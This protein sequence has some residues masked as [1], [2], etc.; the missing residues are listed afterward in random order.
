M[1]ALLILI[2]SS[3]I[4]FT[5]S[6]QMNLSGVA[7]G[8]CD[9]YTLTDFTNQTGSVWSPGTIDLT[10]TFDMSFEVN[11]GVDDVWGAD[12]MVFALRQTGTSPGS[13]GNGM[14]YGG[15]TNSIGVEI[16]TWNSSPAVPTDVASDHMAM[17]SNGGVDHDL[18]APITIANIEDGLYHTFRAT[19]DPVAFDLEIFLDGA[20]IFT[21]NG[22]MVALFFGG[23]PDVYFGWTG[24]TGGVDNIQSVCMYRD[25][26]FS[27]DVITAC[28]DQT[29]TF[30]DESTSDL[31]YDSEEAI[32]WDWDFGDGSSSALEN[33]TR[34]YATVGT[35]T[36]TLTITD[37]SG[38]SSVETFDIDITAGLDITMT[39]TDVTCFG[40]DDGTGTAMPT[41]GIGP[42]TYLWDDPLAQTTGT[43][44]GLSPNTYDVIVTDD[45]G[46]TGTG[47]VTILEPTELIIL[48]STPTNASCG[49]A[50]GS[51]TIVG[52]GG[53]PVLEFSIDGG[54]TYQSTG[55]FPG[56]TNGT[57]DVVIRDANGCMA[58]TTTIVDL[59][60]PL[61]IDAV[62]ATDDS[63]LPGDDGTITVTASSGAAP[64][65]YS[66]DG[67]A[68]YQLSNFFDLLAP[69]AYTV[70]VMDDVGCTVTEDIVV[71]A[72]LGIV[73]DLITVVDATCNGGS[74]GSIDIDVSG[75][76][77]AY[78]YSIDA[79]V[80]FVPTDLFTGLTAGTY[81][82]EISDA[83]GCVV[84]N[85]AVIGEP[86]LITIDGVLATDVSC[87]GLSDGEFELVVSGGTPGYLYSND[88]GATFQISPTFTGMTAGTFDLMI[89]DANG[90]IIVGVTDVVEPMPIV[91]DDVIVTDVTCNGLMDGEVTIV[92][93]GGT[94][95]YLYNVDGGLDQVSPTFTGLGGGAITVG[96]VDANGCTTTVDAFLDEADPIVL[97]MGPDTTI[98]LGGEAELCPTVT[99]GTAPYTYIWDG[100]PDTECLITSVIGV[101]TLEIEDINGCTTEILEQTVNQYIPLS[102]FGSDAISVCP[103]DE[104]IIAGEAAGDGPAGYTYEWTN[105]V[106]GSVL[107]GPVQTV[108][109]GST[110]TYTLTV[111]SGC[112]NT[113]TTT[114]TVTTFDIPNIVIVADV[115]EG[116]EDLA[117]NFESLTDA[118]LVESMIWDLGDGSIAAGDVVSHTYT[119]ADCFDV[120]VDVTTVDGCETSASFIDYICV[121]Q[122]PVAE[123]SYNPTEPDLYNTTVHFVNES[124]FASSFEW[125][126]GDGGGSTDFEP[127]HTYPSLG[128]ITYDVQLVANTDKGCSDTINHLVTI[129]EIV[130]YFIPNA[131]TP[132]S[133]PFNQTF[134]PVFIP[135]FYP[136]DYHIRILNRWGEVLWESY[137]IAGGWDGTYDGAFVQDGVYVWELTFRE[138]K[139][140]KKFRD[141][142]HITLVQ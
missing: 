108:T 80:S 26:D 135:G 45:L 114:I 101:H 20:S 109:P 17:N 67:G 61:V 71:G 77:P 110:T 102:V 119:Y 31:I 38:C 129:D 39:H 33:P 51:I 127:S 1:R 138:N 130:L 66:L 79:G 22:D 137:D 83:S 18:V 15:I 122:M 68:T 94:V 24:G 46:C 11:L 7:S 37:I 87:T 50:N 53:A 98:C 19:W 9:C 65:Q 125:T 118:S 81:D 132:N 93:S 142:G 14:G 62:A 123:F 78:Q 10:N 113:A 116:C 58:T 99:G 139:T 56:L 85:V 120:N 136:K 41:T 12:G 27:T 13:I 35:Y 23:T 91:I 2:V 57:Y 49:L 43:S 74:D 104:V 55:D 86:S 111:S 60:S 100:A 106:D 141:F 112:E 117:V 105:D 28:V 96:V 8:S 54:L 29:I 92:A 59:D 52:S 133:D 48:S 36:I 128:N 75:G 6:A 82:V 134:N 89:E 34:A 72:I 90:C 107:F 76:T 63:C 30:T 3:F 140:D 5:G 4:A 21:Y 25:A 32:T 121:W 88:A 84:T 69:G 131:F 47:S 115:Y 64:F 42:Y 95:A 73:V 126:F 16:D 103:G 124:E 40:M 70:T 97:T 44:V